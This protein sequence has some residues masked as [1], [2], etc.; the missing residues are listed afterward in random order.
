MKQGCLKLMPES[1]QCGA[2]PTASGRLFQCVGPLFA[3]DHLN[4]F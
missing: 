2:D 3:K 4:D 1:C